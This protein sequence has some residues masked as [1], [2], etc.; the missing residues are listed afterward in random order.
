MC[1]LLRINANCM[2]VVVLQY[3]VVFNVTLFGVSTWKIKTANY[4]SFLAFSNLGRVV[5][6]L[7]RNWPYHFV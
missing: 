7:L 3:T 4:K 5:S 6:K 2:S 1:I